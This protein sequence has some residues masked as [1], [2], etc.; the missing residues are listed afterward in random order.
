VDVAICPYKVFNVAFRFLRH[1]DQAGGMKAATRWTPEM[2][3]E[4]VRMSNDVFAPQVNIHFKLADSD[5]VTTEELHQPIGD[6]AFKQYLVKHKS[7]KAD[8]TVFLVGKWKGNDTHP[9]GTYYTEE[10]VAVVN[11]NPSHPEGTD[12]DPFALTLA[13]ELAHHVQHTRS[14]LGHH[15]RE[16]ILLSTG[17][18]SPKLDKQLVADLNP[19]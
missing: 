7:D 15:N 1:K 18:Q 5:W 13:H 4:M 3:K 14:A 19:W 6:Q 12:G 8:V 10:N 9:N 16:K 2:A 11:D 17:I